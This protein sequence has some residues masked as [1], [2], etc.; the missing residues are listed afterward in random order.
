M[1]RTLDGAW[2]LARDPRHEGRAEGWFGAV[3]YLAEVWVNG[4]LRGTV[5]E[6][7]G[8]GNA[9]CEAGADVMLAAGGS[10]VVDPN[11]DYTHDQTRVFAV[12]RYV[13]RKGL[14]VQVR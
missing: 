10:F 12:I 9:L 5:A 6:A 7:A 11:G 13:D 3:D 1:T 2:P 4:R 8:A 14:V